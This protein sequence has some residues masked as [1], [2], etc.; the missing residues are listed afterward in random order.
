[1]IDLTLRCPTCG[2]RA[3]VCFDHGD[4]WKKRRHTT[5]LS[6]L[7]RMTEDELRARV[8]EFTQDDPP[9]YGERA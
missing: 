7:H 2:Q 5:S 1:M 8:H 9:P 4:E 6:V 3:D